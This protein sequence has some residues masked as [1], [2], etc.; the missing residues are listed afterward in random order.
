MKMERKNACMPASILVLSNKGST[1][2]KYLKSL[3]QILHFGAAQHSLGTVS[4]TFQHS[5]TLM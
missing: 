5:K 2:E 3:K 1:S 4:C